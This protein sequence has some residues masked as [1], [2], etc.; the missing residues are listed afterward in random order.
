[1][2]RARLE[3]SKEMSKTIYFT[4]TAL[5][6]IPEVRLDDKTAK[7]WWNWWKSVQPRRNLRKHRPNMSLETRHSPTGLL[8]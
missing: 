4:V 5:E 8:F 1:M 2:P 7:V 3:G 6:I